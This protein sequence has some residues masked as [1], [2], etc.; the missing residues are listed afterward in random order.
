MLLWGKK[1]KFTEGKIRLQAYFVLFEDALT[2]ATSEAEIAVSHSISEDHLPGPACPDAF[3][4]AKEPFQSAPFS[5]ETPKEPPL[6]PFLHLGPLDSF[7]NAL[8]QPPVPP[9][10][11]SALAVWALDFLDDDLEKGHSGT[12]RRSTRGS[13]QALTNT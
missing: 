13:A 6:P 2:P 10:P 11:P 3:P 12:R 7:S 9:S 4:E 1:R 5:P 8:S